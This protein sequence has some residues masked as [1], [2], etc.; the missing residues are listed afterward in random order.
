MPRTLL[1]VGVKN[2]GRAVALHFARRGWTVAYALRALLLVAA[3]ELRPKL[4]HVAYL[5]IEGGI[6]SE[7]SQGYV[8]RVGLDKTLPPDEIA[9]AVAF[10]HEQD[11]RSWTHE[12]SL[13]PARTEW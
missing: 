13:K 8:A 6:E 3:Q 5:A 11:P 9:R 2:L 7:K 1:V 10:L 12:L 4:L